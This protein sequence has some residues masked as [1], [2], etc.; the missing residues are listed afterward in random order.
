MG[1]KVNWI[2]ALK[3]IY[4]NKND[5]YHSEVL[6]HLHHF[7]N[8]RHSCNPITRFFTCNNGVTTRLS[9]FNNEYYFLLIRARF[10]MQCCRIYCIIFHTD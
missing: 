10:S 5:V 3:S 7:S 6:R 9:T 1:R 2:I 8:V 4:T